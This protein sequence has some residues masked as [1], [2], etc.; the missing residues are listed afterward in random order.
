[1][2]VDERLYV[3]DCGH[4]QFQHNHHTHKSHHHDAHP[5][6]HA[7]AVLGDGDLL[8]LLCGDAFMRSALISSPASIN[9]GTLSVTSCTLVILCR[10]ATF[11][12]RLACDVVGR[13]MGMG[14]SNGMEMN[15]NNGME[16]DTK[17]WK[18]IRMDRH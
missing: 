10:L 15:T 9:R 2:L 8:K 16:M 14:Y 11:C 6:I 7:D 17:V 1:M 3:G 18:S 4:V 13:G 12:R 5:L